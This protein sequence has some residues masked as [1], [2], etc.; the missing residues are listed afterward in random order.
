MIFKFVFYLYYLKCVLDSNYIE[1]V[2]KIIVSIPNKAD[3]I[4][5]DSKND[6]G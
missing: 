6:D 1:T 4:Y 2:K 5:C 3:I